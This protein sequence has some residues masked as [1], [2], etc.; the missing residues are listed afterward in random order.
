SNTER[1]RQQPA[2]KRSI[3]LARVHAV[4]LE[5]EQVVRDVDAG[6]SRAEGRKEQPEMH[7]HPR[8]QQQVSRQRRDKHQQVLHPLVGTQLRHEGARDPQRPAVVRD[9]NCCRHVSPCA[10]CCQLLNISIAPIN[11]SSALPWAKLMFSCPSATVTWKVLTR[12][13]YPPAWAK[14]SRLSS[15]SWFSIDTSKTRRPTACPPL[16]CSTKCSF[17]V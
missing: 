13:V 6:R 10:A 8:L 15:T 14:I 2:R 1:Q 11:G 7:Q 5:I 16:Q 3:A 17:T 4:A 12:S 9:W